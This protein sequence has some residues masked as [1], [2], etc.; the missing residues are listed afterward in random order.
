[1]GQTGGHRGRYR[2]V[3]A[4]LVYVRPKGLANNPAYTQVVAARGETTVYISGQVSLDAS[5][6]T[7]G[8]TREGVACAA[9]NGNTS[10]S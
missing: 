9:G 1:M 5:G 4:E 7:V 2:A 3:M 10:A 8:S 6:N